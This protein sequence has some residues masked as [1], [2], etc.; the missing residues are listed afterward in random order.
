M[1]TLVY[2]HNGGVT[3]NNAKDYP[4][5]KLLTVTVTLVH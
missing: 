1:A 4:A 5:T 3:L 2:I